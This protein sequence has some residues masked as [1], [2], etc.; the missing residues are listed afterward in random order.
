MSRS[1]V[2][3]AIALVLAGHVTHSLAAG[4]PERR[5]SER[6][7]PATLAITHVSVADGSGAPLQ[8]DMKVLVRGTRITAVGP[9][10][11]TSVPAGARVIDGSGRYLIPGLWDMHVHLTVAGRT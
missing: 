4:A 3:F 10:A 6:S 9:S 1:V 5:G 8:R 7:P 2:G 11:A